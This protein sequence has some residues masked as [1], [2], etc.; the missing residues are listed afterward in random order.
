MTVEHDNSDRLLSFDKR[1]IFKYVDKLQQLIWDND[2]SEIDVPGQGRTWVSN[3]IGLKVGK[4]IEI[5]WSRWRDEEGS[6]VWG[7]HDGLRRGDY[8]VMYVDP[9]NSTLRI[10][11]LRESGKKVLG[12][13]LN[14]F[15]DILTL[16]DKLRNYKR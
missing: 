7:S 5:G 9:Y 8:C 14:D 11:E 6:L 4:D 3:V 16:A 12:I 1:Q 13:E 10:A 2:A 15:N